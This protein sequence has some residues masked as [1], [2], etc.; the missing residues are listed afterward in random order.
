M[1]RVDDRR[2]LNGTFW[3]LRSGAPWRD[4]P[5][6]Y[7]PKTTCYRGGVVAKLSDKVNKERLERLYLVDGLSTNQLAQRLGSNRESVR[8]LLISY[9][10]PLRPRSFPRIRG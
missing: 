10:I 4:L 3:V 7:G 5:E 2:V 8:K 1:P 9:G 6:R